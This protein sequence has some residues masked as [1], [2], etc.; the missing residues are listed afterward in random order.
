MVT[1]YIIGAGCSR[2]YEQCQSPVPRLQPPVNADFFKMAK[3]IVDFYD[4]SHMFGP[5][6]GLDHFTRNLNRLYGYGESEFD[7]TVFNDDR[8]TLEG[9]MTHFHLEYE[10][11]HT[12]LAS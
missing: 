1:L 3:K 12:N 8:L 7:T 9:V 5:I 10:L 4:L 6:P 2:N 11:L